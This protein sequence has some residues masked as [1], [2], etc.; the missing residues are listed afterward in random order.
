[1]R[2]RILGLRLLNRALDMP[3]TAR[4]PNDPLDLLNLESHN[5][6]CS[7]QPHA[8]DAQSDRSDRGLRARPKLG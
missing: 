3:A 4:L 5:D 6:E 1:M 2:N 8:P 7:A